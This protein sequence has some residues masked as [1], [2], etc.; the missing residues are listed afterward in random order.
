MTAGKFIPGPRQIGLGG[1]DV[2][3]VVLPGRSRGAEIHRVDQGNIDPALWSE[4]SGRGKA[5]AQ[6]LSLPGIFS[7]E[8]IARRAQIVVRRLGHDQLVN[9]GAGRRLQAGT[10]VVG[11]R[12]EIPVLGVVEGVEQ[13]GPEIELIRFGCLGP[14]CIRRVVV[15]LRISFVEH[16]PRQF[17]AED[18]VVAVPVERRHV[19]VVV[20]VIDHVDGELGQ[21]VARHHNWGSG[22]GIGRVAGAR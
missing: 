18:P 19:I 13:L 14:R 11:H 2:E 5:G 21:P 15:Q 22:R 4:A 1:Q 7:A 16:Q 17:G 12:R 10:A 6:G 3:A 8:D 9:R 20:E